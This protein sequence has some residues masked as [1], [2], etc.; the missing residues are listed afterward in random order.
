MGDFAYPPE[1]AQEL[2]NRFTPLLAPV[3]EQFF[4]E[5]GF[6]DASDIREF[7]HKQIQSIIQTKEIALYLLEK[8]PWD[9]AVVHFFALDPLQ[10]ALWHGIDSRHPGFNSETHQEVGAFFSALDTAMSDLIEASHASAVMVFSEHGFTACRGALNLSRLLVE[11]GIVQHLRFTE[12]VLRRVP[13][14]RRSRRLNRVLRRFDERIRR[15]A[16]FLRWPSPSIFLE[17]KVIYINISGKS[18]A[19]MTDRVVRALQAI[20]DPETGSRVVRKAWRAEELYRT[21]KIPG[22]DILVLEMEDGYTGR[23]GELHWP[24]TWS[25]RPNQEYLSGTHT[26]TGL[27]VLAG[28]GVTANDCFPAGIL[29]LPPTL[30]TYLG[31]DVPEWMEGT[32][33]QIPGLVPET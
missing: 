5:G 7:V 6:R 2:Q 21:P 26:R 3:W 15:R 33:L 31:V 32:V 28:R 4:P 23:E 9:I 11:E 16:P 19:R 12:R 25:P 18:D 1:L 30:L 20:E 14:L 13:L 8:G 24:M 22:W 27:W 10:H 29:D 17:T